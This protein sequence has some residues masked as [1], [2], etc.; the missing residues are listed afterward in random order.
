MATVCVRV[1]SAE[2]CLVSWTIFQTE[3]DS[4]SLLELFEN[5]KNG[6]VSIIPPSPELSTARVEK[7][8]IGKSKE[9]LTNIDPN[10]Q[11]CDVLVSFGQ[12]IRYNVVISVT[13][14]VSVGVTTLVQPNIFAYMMQNSA[15]MAAAERV[16]LPDLLPERNNKDKLFNAIIAFLEKNDFT[17]ISKGNLHGAPFVRALSSALWYIDGHHHTLKEAGCPVPEMFT[18]FSGFNRPEISKHRKRSV[19]NMDAN[20]LKQHAT[21][22][23]EFLLTSWIKHERWK[24]MY[25]S[26]DLLASSLEK[27]VFHLIEKKQ[28]YLEPKT[29]G[30]VIADSIHIKVLKVSDSSSS[31]LS[32]LIDE[33]STKGNYE[34]FFVGDF[35]PPKR[36]DRFYYIRQLENGLPFRTV[37]CTF[38]FGGS[39]RNYHFVWKIPTDIDADALLGENQKVIEQVKKDIPVFHKKSFRQEFIN[40]CGTLLPGAK[41]YALREIFKWI[42]GTVFKRCHTTY[43]ISLPYR[44]C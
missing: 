2:K 41:C 14:P 12:F 35:T 3:S 24:Q 1:Q 23:K 25:Q 22:L 9:I 11:L 43:C 40:H 36:I 19:T 32:S 42:T 44:G 8:F 34:Y 39:I 33:L 27:Y 37:L 26:L 29:S 28:K 30:I 10:I 20:N 17:W 15:R 4:H 13:T 5:V 6:R 18:G 16:P 38:S 7:V 31:Q 21:A